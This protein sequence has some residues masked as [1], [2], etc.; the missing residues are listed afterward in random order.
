MKELDFL[1]RQ[2]REARRRRLLMRRNGAFMIVLVLGFAGLHVVTTTRVRSAEAALES[3]R[4][5]DRER[6]AE[7]ARLSAIESEMTTLRQDADLVDRLEDDAPMHVVL[8]EL[9]RMMTK[10]MAIVS[11]SAAWAAPP[12][13]VEGGAAAPPG[14]T[15]APTRKADPVFDRGAMRMELV[16]VAADNIDIGFFMGKLTE[17]PL[18]RDVAM[19]Y[20]H[21]VERDGR[22]MREF[23]LSFAVNRVSVEQSEPGARPSE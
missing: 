6:S 2:F 16:G 1:P 12:G 18:F 4:S 7:L 20:S 19:G 8:A 15:A 9:T 3:L 17:S 10:S 14:T 22:Q 21:T 23:K 5:G 11:L 13:G